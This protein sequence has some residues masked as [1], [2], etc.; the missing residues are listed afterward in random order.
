MI[1]LGPGCG[2]KNTVIHEIMHALGFWHEQSRP[3]R[4]QYVKIHDANIVPGM[5]HNFARRHK[6]EIN[7]LGSPYDYESIMHYRSFEFSKDRGNKH[8]ITR[9]NSHLRTSFNNNNGLSNQDVIQLKKLYKCSGKK[10]K[11]H[12]FP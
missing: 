4:D 8:T 7:S 12:K 11:N 6:D 5:K 1:N 2:Y 3:D 9:K 10:F